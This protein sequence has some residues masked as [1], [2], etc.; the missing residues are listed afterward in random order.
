MWIIRFDSYKVEETRATL[1][2]AIKGWNTAD[3]QISLESGFS[4]EVD[5]NVVIR[6]ANTALAEHLARTFKVDWSEVEHS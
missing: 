5:A 3:L 2:E 4:T 6:T 1:D